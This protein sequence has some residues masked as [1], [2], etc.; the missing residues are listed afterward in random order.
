M[1]GADSK[2]IQEKD[3]GDRFEVLLESQ[4]NG[5]VFRL[6]RRL[7]R[8]SETWVED[9]ST[10][11]ATLMTY[12]QLYARRAVCTNRLLR[13][14]KTMN[15]YM[16]QFGGPRK[17]M[18]KKTGSAFWLHLAQTAPPMF[19]AIES[20]AAYPC[21]FKQSSWKPGSTD[22]R[23]PLDNVNTVQ[24]LTLTI[25]GSCLDNHPDG[26]GVVLWGDYRT[27]VFEKGAPELKRARVATKP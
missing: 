11:L 19:D 6:T 2:I 5:K 23:G 13:L 26:S 24:D 18:S 12:G 9:W 20:A 25:V 15:S 3:E 4:S 16:I 8:E 7:I 21:P 27:E 1:F 17:S 10:E 22:Y 14:W